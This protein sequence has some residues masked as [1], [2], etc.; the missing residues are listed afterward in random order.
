MSKPITRSI[1]VAG[2]LDTPRWSPTT[3]TSPATVQTDMVG[4]YGGEMVK[5]VRNVI[6]PS[7]LSF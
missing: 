7:Y 1:E 6:S 5:R 4:K 2:L 3:A